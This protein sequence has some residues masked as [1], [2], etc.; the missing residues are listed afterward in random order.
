[1]PQQILPTP[2]SSSDGFSQQPVAMESHTSHP[3]GSMSPEQSFAGYSYS[4][5]YSTPVRDDDSSVYEPST[6][7]SQG[8]DVSFQGYAGGLGITSNPY[9][10]LT[11]EIGYNVGCT[12]AQEEPTAEPTKQNHLPYTPE[13]SPSAPCPSSD[14]ITTRSGLNIAKKSLI[15]RSPAVKTGRVQK[16]SRAE[17]AKNATNMLSKPLSEAARDF[18]DIHVSD[19]EAFV[20]RPTEERLSETS[21]N[22]KAGQIKRPMNAFM[23]YRKAYQ[24][25]AKTQCSQNNHQHVS[26]VCGAAWVL[27]PAQI[28]ENFDQWARIERVNHQRAH[29]GYKF[30]P[31]KP[32]K[33]KRDGDG[34]D[35]Y[36]D[37]DSGWNGGGG[38]KSRFRHA[39]RLG[40]TPVA[41]DAASNAIGEPAIPSYHDIG[42]NINNEVIS[43]TPSP[44]AIDYPVHG[45]DGFANYY[46]PPGSS[47][48]NAAPH[49]FGPAQY[50]IYDGI[51]ATVPFDQEGWVSHVESGQGLMPVMGGYEDTTAQ[52]VYLKGSK[53]DWKVEIMDE[54]GHF[55][56]WYA[57]TEQ[58]LQ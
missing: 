33:V 55:E 54:P 6:V 18:P 43:R 29:P 35:D 12:R 57:Q 52:D 44:G 22:K 2:P 26:K 31:S 58:G 42:L 40:E 41:Y 1:M 25:V 16:R 23:L 20:S 3:Q 9:G 10:P 8:S 51:P 39:T 14:A 32:R 17:K 37:N 27:E 15:S 21:R 50:D 24:E 13:A 47:F 5:R 34:N 49:L 4:T 38:R 19:I 53:D 56:D 30:T 28:K 46:G 45:L 7:Y 11:D 36:S 48:D